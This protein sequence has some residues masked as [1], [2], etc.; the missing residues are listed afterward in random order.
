MMVAIFSALALALGAGLA[1]AVR[2]AVAAGLAGL[3]LATGLFLYEI[4]S[5]ATGFRLP[6]LQV[7]LPAP[8]TRA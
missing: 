1:G 6:W 2:L 5:P 7:A 3:A 4:E 8:G